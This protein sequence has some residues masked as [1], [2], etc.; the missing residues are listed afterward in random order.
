MF[1]GEIEI[2]SRRKVPFLT[3]LHSQFRGVGQGM[4]QTYLYLW[5]P[6]LQEMIS[7]SPLNIPFI[8]SNISAYGVYAIF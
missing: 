5:S 8:C 7:I 6:L 4:K 2:I 3:D 1:N